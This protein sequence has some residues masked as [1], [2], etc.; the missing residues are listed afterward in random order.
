MIASE[1][2]VELGAFPL[3]VPTIKYGFAIDTFQVLE[4]SIR[5]GQFLADILLAQKVDYP[6]IEKIV[7]NS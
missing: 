6:S 1:K 7:A 5:P 3:V 4:R 2:P